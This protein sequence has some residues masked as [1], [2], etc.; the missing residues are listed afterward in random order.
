M[1]EGGDPFGAAMAALLGDEA[2]G[3]SRRRRRRQHDPLAVAAPGA[4]PPGQPR[5]GHVPRDA[6]VERRARVDEM[7]V[8]TAD[9]DGLPPGADD[10]AG[11][12]PVAV[13][14]APRDPLLP[15]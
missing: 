14:R 1:A 9:R 13:W 5:H 7:V 11:G 3:S 4:L 2:P 15:G 12:E 8:A 10:A 6:R